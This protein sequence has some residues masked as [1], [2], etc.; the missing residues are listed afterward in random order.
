MVTYASHVYYI[1]SSCQWLKALCAGE[2]VVRLM[3]NI[4]LIILIPR[5]FACSER[6][7]GRGC[8]NGVHVSSVITSSGDIFWTLW[9]R[10]HVVSKTCSTDEPS[11]G[12][13]PLDSPGAFPKTTKSRAS[14][15]SIP[16]PLNNS[17]LSHVLWQPA[18][19]ST[20]LQ[21]YLHETEMAA[22]I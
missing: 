16:L 8:N 4:L 3:P 15:Y 6:K 19:L 20:E 11:D 10:W 18:L 1:P 14:R 17:H 13:V 2:M 12:S 21:S 5:P 22:R 7:L 9:G